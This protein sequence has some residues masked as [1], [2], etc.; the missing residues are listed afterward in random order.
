MTLEY[1]ALTAAAFGIVALG[2][3]HSVLGETGIV[4]PIVKRMAL[5]LRR[6]E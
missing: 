2:L 4:K 1:I 3:A 6:T 5:H